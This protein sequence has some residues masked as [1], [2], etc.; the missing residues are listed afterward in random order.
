[1]A[2]KL[3]ISNRKMGSGLRTFERCNVRKKKVNERDRKERERDKQSGGLLRCHKMPAVLLC[4]HSPLITVLFELSLCLL[5]HTHTIILSVYS[6]F[7]DYLDLLSRSRFM[8]SG[9]ASHSNINWLC[10]WVGAQNS[11]MAMFVH[12]VHVCM[13]ILNGGDSYPIKQACFC[14]F[15]PPDL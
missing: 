5:P 7:T 10:V 8:T 14:S 12:G 15:Y 1:M 6:M 9:A 13:C 11:M 3:H 2:E 4:S